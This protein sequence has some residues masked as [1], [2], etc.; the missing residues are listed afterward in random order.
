MLKRQTVTSEVAAILRQR[1]IGGFYEGGD[2]IRQEAL[3]AELGVSRIPV[4]EAL[5]QLESEGLL[6]IHTH[7]GAMVAWLS[8][9]DAREVF[10]ARALLEPFILRKAMAQ[11]T[12]QHVREAEQALRSYERAIEHDSG[13]DE[14]SR[15]NWNFHI[16]LCEPAKRPRSLAILSGLHNSADRYLR[17]QIVSEQARASALEDHRDLMQ[18]YAAGDVKRAVKLL[19]KH[20]NAAAAEVMDRLDQPEIE[21]RRARSA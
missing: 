12:D 3:A 16:R 4:R 7:R 10:E 8:P 21:P 13:P 1:I 20:I 14:L 18:A 11:R 2:Q 19:E 6:T 9:E 5:L 15:L 17:I